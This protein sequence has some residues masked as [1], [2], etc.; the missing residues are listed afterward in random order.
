MPQSR[1]VVLLDGAYLDH[2][3]QGPWAHGGRPLP[4]D[5]R[6]LTRH[7]N[8]GRRPQAVYYYYALPWISDPPLPAE[9]HFRGQQEKFLAFLASD[10]RWVLREGRVERRGGT[11]P[12]DWVFEQ[13]RTDVQIAVDMVRLAWRGEAE[14]IILLAGDSDL[15]PALEDA[16]A[17]GIRITLAYHPGAV[18][19]D[20]LAA[21]DDA[22]ALLEPDMRQLT[23][24]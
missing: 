20:M 10:P 13:K 18:H 19:R 23:R 16:K 8:Q 6:R 12:G 21:C 15:I 7:L 24:Q 1:A 9:H 3:A 11:R 22:V 17:A 5:L 4:L 2:L 14:H